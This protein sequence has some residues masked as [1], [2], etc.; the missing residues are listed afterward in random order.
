VPGA[1]TYTG[2]VDTLVRP[3]REG[4]RRLSPARPAQPAGEAG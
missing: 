3:L 1:P 4:A 2:L